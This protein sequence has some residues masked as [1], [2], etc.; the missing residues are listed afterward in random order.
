MRRQR[1]ETP[2]DFYR[3]F[4]AQKLC[5]AKYLR[6]IELRE[7][8]VDPDQIKVC[9][10]SVDSCDCQSHVNYSL[11]HFTRQV[12]LDQPGR[13]L[14]SS[15]QMANPASP[16]RK[17][18]STVHSPQCHNEREL[19]DKCKRLN[20]TDAK[21]M[22]VERIPRVETPPA[23]PPPEVDRSFDWQRSFIYAEYLEEKGVR[24]KLDADGFYRP[25]APE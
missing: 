1:K 23:T 2:K 4:R 24:V 22:L 10:H 3:K 13:Q 6:E 25:L 15:H 9:E 16:C 14:Q 21:L 8:S 19:V 17:T 7:R 20:Q 5:D 11:D 18:C 12:I